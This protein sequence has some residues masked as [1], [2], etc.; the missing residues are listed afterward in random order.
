MPLSDNYNYNVGDRVRNDTTQEEGRVLNIE[1]LAGGVLLITVAVFIGGI[2]RGNKDF[3]SKVGQIAG[4]EWSIL[5]T[6]VGTSA[7]K[8]SLITH[9]ME[10][11][12]V[13]AAA[14]V[15]ASANQPSDRSVSKAIADRLTA[16]N[17]KLANRNDEEAFANA[18]FDRLE[19]LRRVRAGVYKKKGDIDTLMNYLTATGRKG[20]GGQWEGSYLVELVHNTGSANA[21]AIQQGDKIQQILQQTG[22]PVDLGLR[23]K[24]FIPDGVTTAWE[25]LVHAKQKIKGMSYTEG[26][27]LW[28]EYA[29]ILKRA[30]E[31]SPG[32]KR[33]QSRID[34]LNEAT[35]FTGDWYGRL[36][37]S[38]IG[39]E[40][41]DF[42]RFGV[43]GGVT[44]PEADARTSHVLESRM[45]GAKAKSFTELEMGV[46]ASRFKKPGQFGFGVVKKTE[47]PIAKKTRSRFLVTSVKEENLIEILPGFRVPRNTST[48][49]TRAEKRSF[50]PESEK[51]DVRRPGTI[52]SERARGMDRFHPKRDERGPLL[53][54]ILEG[55]ETVLERDIGQRTTFRRTGIGRKKVSGPSVDE[56]FGG[57]ISTT[58]KA[59][60]WS[61]KNPPASRI[62]QKNFE[63]QTVQYQGLPHVITKID[64]VTRQATLTPISTP[65]DLVGTDV[66]GMPVS[67]IDA[68]KGISRK[69]SGLPLEAD[70][71]AQKAGQEAKRIAERIAARKTISVRGGLLGTTNDT[72]KVP[73]D[74]LREY[75]AGP[76]TFK[77]ADTLKKTG[78][79]IFKDVAALRLAGFSGTEDFSRRSRSFSTR[80]EKT[81][82][83]KLSTH[84]TVAGLTGRAAEQRLEEVMAGARLS[85]FEHLGVIQG[86]RSIQQIEQEL[87]RVGI[88]RGPNVARDSLN[89]VVASTFTEFDRVNDAG[90]VIQSGLDR[91]DSIAAR[92]AAS[93]TTEFL[94]MKDL[95]AR[96]LQF[97]KSAGE[98]L[99]GE[100]RAYR[101][102]VRETFG[103]NINNPLETGMSIEAL[104]ENIRTGVLG[105]TEARA[106]LTNLARELGIV[107]IPSK[108]PEALGTARIT[109]GNEESF[110]NLYKAVLDLPADQHAAALRKLG[111]S[112][113]IAGGESAAI[114]HT[115]GG[116]RFNV[117][118]VRGGLAAISPTNPNVARFM[119]GAEQPFELGIAE[120]AKSMSA[121]EFSVSNRTAEQV[122]ASIART[123]ARAERE[124]FVRNFVGE[125]PST[126][127]M[128][129]TKAGVVGFLGNDLVNAKSV[130]ENA[131][132]A[133]QAKRALLFIDIETN[134]EVNQITNFA[135]RRLEMVNG[136]WQMV[137]EAINIAT[138]A[139]WQMHGV[140]GSAET[141]IATRFGTTTKIG[142][143][144][145][146]EQALAQRAA[147]IIG[148]HQDA[149]V[150]GHNIPFDI[151]KLAKVQGLETSAAETLA[152]VARSRVTDTLLLAQITHPG[153]SEFSLGALGRTLTGNMGQQPHLADPDVIRNIEVFKEIAARSEQALAG[154][155][156]I[157][158]TKLGPDSVIFAQ[159]GDRSIRGRAFR[160]AGVL[161]T[162]AASEAFF[163]KTGKE[164]GVGFGVAL[165][166]IDFRTGQAAGP[167]VLNFAQTPHGWARSAAGNFQVTDKITG[168]SQME[169]TAADLARRRIRRVTSDEGS[170]T[171]LIEERL[172]VG[173]GA[174][175]GRGDEALATT[176]DKLAQR[177]RTTDSPAERQVLRNVLGHSEQFLGDSRLLRQLE[178]ERG[179]LREVGS[180]HKPV[181]DWLKQALFDAPAGNVR[182]TRQLV[183]DVWTNYMSQVAGAAPFP[184]I[185]IS[186]KSTVSLNIPVLGQNPRALMTHSEDA[187]RFSLQQTVLDIAKKVKG[188]Q[189]FN[190]L[191]ATADKEEIHRATT[192]LQHGE[193]FLDTT[194]G[195]T[196]ESHIFE[197]YIAPAM[198]KRFVQL[199]GKANLP[200][201][202]RAGNIQDAVASILSRTG[203]LANENKEVASDYLAG[204]NITNESV[205]DIQRRIGV[206]GDLISAAERSTTPDNFRVGFHH[207]APRSWN[208][209]TF[210]DLIETATKSTAEEQENFTGRLRGMFKR[211]A[212]NDQEVLT[213]ILKQKAPD[214]TNTVVGMA[215]VI[216]S[217]KASRDFNPGTL[218]NIGLQVGELAENNAN[219]LKVVGLLGLGVIAAGVALLARRP[220][221]SPDK[222]NEEEDRD[223]ILHSTEFE[224]NRRKERMANQVPLV[225]KITV[226]ISGEDPNGADHE[227]LIQSVHS[228]LGT[229]L[230]R[231]IQRATSMSDNRS[232]IDRGYL[233]RLA[234]RLITRPGPVR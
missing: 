228:S 220:Q 176:Q 204:R 181:Y 78:Q 124:S 169:E 95:K 100:E 101:R 186:P 129:R 171:R 103:N 120:I 67:A 68:I 150:I 141:G 87:L 224:S 57:G 143:V 62:V 175:A 206:G 152:N 123:T 7:S 38:S 195:P 214:W 222:S 49:L 234:T 33:L 79:V 20:A 60:W 97:E 148:Q 200:L 21:K 125:V 137:G 99:G 56:L 188:E 184:E 147:Q 93:S 158:Q 37:S 219:N 213:Q 92:H 156:S 96:V 117:R 136:E 180:V 54:S 230:G 197:R 90:E 53:E 98:L 55:P 24:D 16:W 185:P 149:I 227:E 198:E 73:M 203:Q 42:S 145:A 52:A 110:V 71:V 47:I 165:Q 205:T 194:L 199:D 85:I 9:P 225:N 182:Q 86:G 74:L 233:D 164:L 40:S 31:L 13:S 63:G 119:G 170:F 173:L 41:H 114:L 2:L 155:S 210:M 82:R 208:G 64:R 66:A 81:L 151:T 128:L 50:I 88:E 215:E 231:E 8:T 179:F 226:N 39:G 112:R 178:L 118:Q 153:Q 22:I 154:L 139:L 75:L 94:S 19:N 192:L 61:S 70:A 177:L 131:K 84:P 216:E 116:E 126:L 104:A 6:A 11:G 46:K 43:F 201:Q 122:Q 91:I 77:N 27:P 132:A 202:V 69:G 159:Q 209:K 3:I 44:E 51:F 28:N 113:S 36:T 17:P 160:V 102:L 29:Q 163:K 45:F 58:S 12:T 162:E 121:G 135:L 223:R 161:D 207:N 217:S 189:S 1:P 106:G 108:L 30:V 89:S 107:A 144:L 211:M 115:P 191:F 105:K 26:N 183:N 83:E 18:V 196:I 190:D 138:P 48:L 65:V 229:F 127:P 140:G 14:Q 232:K 218:T 187:L 32:R 5:G 34:A 109:P 167:S 10:G 80:F 146:N 174:A 59:D 4:L 168:L 166:P 212:S 133:M 193:N 76:T 35:D 72:V 157:E 172:R 130:I 111:I 134:R 221:S 15:I 142:E 25:L 23:Y